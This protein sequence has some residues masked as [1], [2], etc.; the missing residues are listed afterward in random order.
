MLKRSIILSTILLALYIIASL[1]LFNI[2]QWAFKEIISLGLA[3]IMSFLNMA[4]TLF[5]IEKKLKKSH[6]E[7]VKGFIVSLVSRMVVLIAIFFTIEA[8]MVLNYFVF[9]IAFFILYFLFQI[10]EIY[11]LHT[12]KRSGI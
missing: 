5:I 6:N 7:F 3:G 2:N 12:H 4:I 9:G 11:I 10:I 8:K 1:L